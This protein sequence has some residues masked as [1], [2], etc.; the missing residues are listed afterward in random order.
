MENMVED[1]PALINGFIEV[2]STANE[3][4]AVYHLKKS[5]YDLRVLLQGIQKAVLSYM[6]NPNIVSRTLRVQR[7]VKRYIA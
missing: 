4:E 1:M 3:E 5:N 7:T 6:E 2:C